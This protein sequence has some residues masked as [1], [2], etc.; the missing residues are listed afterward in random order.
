M[1][2]FQV[3]N[4]T[5]IKDLRELSEQGFLKRKKQGKNIYYTSKKAKNYFYNINIQ[6]LFNIK[7]VEVGEK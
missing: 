6:I 7:I 4:K 2:I 1:N 5:A 3:T